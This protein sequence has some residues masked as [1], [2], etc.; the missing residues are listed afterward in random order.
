MPGEK[1]P[2]KVST[3]QTEEEKVPLCTTHGAKHPAAE[4]LFLEKHRRRLRIHV[5]R[6]LSNR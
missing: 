4:L 3:D 1:P 5:D 2:I 6:L